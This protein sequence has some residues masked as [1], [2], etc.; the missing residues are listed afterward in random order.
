MRQHTAA[1]DGPGSAPTLASSGGK[2]MT[3]AL[4][5]D[6]RQGRAALGRLGDFVDEVLAHADLTEDEIVTDV[7]GG[8]RRR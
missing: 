6:R 5:K 1:M 8:R 2:S 3:I 7:I 4:A